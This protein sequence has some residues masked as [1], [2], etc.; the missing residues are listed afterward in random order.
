MCYILLFF[1]TRSVC[2]I[3][4]QQALK[5]RATKQCNTGIWAGNHDFFVEK[6]VA[7][8]ALTQRLAWANNLKGLQTGTV[9]TT[10]YNAD[11]T[12]HWQVWTKIHQITLQVQLQ[13]ASVTRPGVCDSVAG[14]R[15]SLCHGHGHVSVT[16]LRP[17]PT[18]AQGCHGRRTVTVAA[19]AAC[20]G[21]TV[22]SHGHESCQRLSNLAAAQAADAGRIMH[23]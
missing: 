22:M 19:A 11:K 8:A 13:I 1:G 5:T 12:P 14:C 3:N 10:D 23:S 17:R 20:S 16:S 2:R 21:A 6:K 4:S 18:K 9:E 15:G 7:S